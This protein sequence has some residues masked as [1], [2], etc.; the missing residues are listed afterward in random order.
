MCFRGDFTNVGH[1]YMIE[2]TAWVADLPTCHT[3][4]RHT[5]QPH[6]TEISV[7]IVNA[8]VFRLRGTSRQ[9]FTLAYVCI[10]ILHT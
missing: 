7:L 6:N 5:V 4:K 9:L 10:Q 3:K 2:T 8:D 1:Y